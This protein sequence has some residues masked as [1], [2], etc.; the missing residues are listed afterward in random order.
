MS[1]RRA[2]P[3]VPDP[4]SLAGERIQRRSSRC[5]YHFIM[6]SQ[7]VHWAIIDQ[8]L[9][10]E[11]IQ[12]KFNMENNKL[13]RPLSI[14]ITIVTYLLVPV[15][16]FGS[17]CG[18]FFFYLSEVE[19]DQFIPAFFL[20]AAF[21]FIPVFF[22]AKVGNHFGEYGVRRPALVDRMMLSPI[23][24][25]LTPTTCQV[26]E[27]HIAWGDVASIE[28]CPCFSL[29]YADASAL[30]FVLDD[31]SRVSFRMPGYHVDMLS[32]YLSVRLQELAPGAPSDVPEV[33]DSLRQT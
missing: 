19:S 5:C 29:L 15:W 16:F 28:C 31:G 20:F 6:S 2:P 27:R 7:E 4:T 9:S 25:E 11:R 21:V 3:V 22:F 1:V 32:S 10:S 33:L 18:G 13:P 14:P 24:I 17:F 23:L 26:R 30:V 12:L 8:E